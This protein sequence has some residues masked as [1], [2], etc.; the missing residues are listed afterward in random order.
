MEPRSAAQVCNSEEFTERVLG[1]S[2]WGELTQ[3]AHRGIREEA[4][5]ESFGKNSYENSWMK[6]KAKA[7]GCSSCK[8]LS[9]RV[10]GESAWIVPMENAQEV[11]HGENSSR[12]L[13]RE[14]LI[15][16]VEGAQ[17]ERSW[18]QLMQ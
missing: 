13:W 7:H 16:L 15:E 1:K 5:G 18:M 8:G 10:H 6:L 3:S 12:E 11:S 9:E 17:G 2:S 14:L 4:L